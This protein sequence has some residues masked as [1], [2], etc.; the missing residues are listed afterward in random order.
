L[1]AVV[2]VVGA[3]IAMERAASEL[4][5]R[6]AVPGIVTGALVLAGV[7][8]LPNAVAAV[9]LALRGRGAAVLSTALNSNAFNILA[10]FLI[11]TTI[12]GQSSTSGQTTFVTTSYLAMTALALAF[13]YFGRG[14]HRRSGLVILATYLVFVGVLLAISF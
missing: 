4:G 9:Y 12:L 5:S 14:L 2:V 11:P 8:S 1:G 10:G 3:S 13:A 7:T 6:H